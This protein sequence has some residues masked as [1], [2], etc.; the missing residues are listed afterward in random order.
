MDLSDVTGT[1]QVRLPEAVALQLSG[2]SDTDAF[3]RSVTD[4]DPVFPTMLSVKISRK[5]RTVDGGADTPVNTYVNYTILDACA[6]PKGYVR[7]KTALELAPLLRHLST[8]TSAIMP[9]RL[10]MIVHSKAHPLSVQY[11]A[12]VFPCM[13]A[14]TVIMTRTKSSCTLQ[15]PFVVTTPDVTDGA[16][17]PQ[18]PDR[19][20]SMKILCNA[21]NRAAFLLVPKHGKPV[22]ALAIVSSVTPNDI[23]AE[24][25][26][27]ITAEEA[28]EL[29]RAIDV[30]MTLAHFLVKLHNAGLEDGR[31]D[32]PAKLWTPQK[33]P[34][35]G[36][37]CRTLGRSPTEADC[38]PMKVRKYGTPETE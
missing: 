6:Q 22:Y 18:N 9:A 20:L 26:E 14:W 28:V 25:V 3:V 38:S 17:E 19:K 24:T 33:T 23:Y 30:E 31:V 4:G 29:T 5:Q 27:Q 7:S 21:E 16:Q 10:S 34:L 37:T 13:K 1:V 2:S 15:A 12:D 36:K 8:M 35:N 32:A 11:K